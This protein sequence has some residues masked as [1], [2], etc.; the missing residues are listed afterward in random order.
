MKSDFQLLV[1][2]LILVATLVICGCDDGSVES[3][4][5]SLLNPDGK[6]TLYVSNQSFTIMRIDI[7]VEVDG[8]LVISE[9]FHVGDQHVFKS[10]RLALKDGKH[11][12]RIR[13][14]KG[15][16]EYSGDFEVAE[17]RIGVIC[18]WYSPKAQTKAKNKHFSFRIQNAPLIII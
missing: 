17:G 11:T 5:S 14:Q 6:F 7:S 13:S 18:Y 12:I 10:F 8:E 4:N 2:G 1:N 16:A 9:R 15:E 3:V